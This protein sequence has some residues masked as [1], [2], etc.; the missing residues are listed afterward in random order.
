MKQASPCR[1]FA[2]QLLLI[3]I[4]TLAAIA[5]LH[6][7][8]PAVGKA[9]EEP[10]MPDV[11]WIK[12]PSTAS[13]KN[14]AEIQVPAGYLFADGDGARKLLESMGNLSS[15]TEVGFLAPTSMVWFAVFRFSADGYVKDDDKDS[16]DAAK[17]LATIRDGVEQ[18]NEDRKRR[19]FPAMK[20]VGWAHPPHYDESTHNLEWALEGESEGGGRVINHN[21]RLL[22]RRGVMEA[23]LVVEP[24]ELAKSL[25]EFKTLLAGYQFKSGEKYAEYRQGD[26]LATYG[27]AAL[28]TGGA[29]A[30][31]AKTGLLAGIAL[32]F[33]KFFKLVIVAVV[34]LF[35]WIRKLIL[36]RNRSDLQ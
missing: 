4:L 1:S 20:V 11:P 22:G 33:K 2:R 7:A 35:A 26:A 5:P 21:T 13:M 12:G 18:S 23:K 36:G 30:A 29:V 17:M 32:F 34:G 31:A 3:A 15:G 28:V 6:A 9:Q 25:P 19:G 16:L 27:L 24:D 14:H 8:T 10:E